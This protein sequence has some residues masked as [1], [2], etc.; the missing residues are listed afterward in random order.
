MTA[1]RGGSRK[2]LT[3]MLV[4]LQDSRPER[5]SQPVPLRENVRGVQPGGGLGPNLEQAWGRLRRWFLQTVRLGYVRRMAELRQ[6]D[7]SGAPHEILDPRDLK[8][9]RNLC[10][11]RWPAEHD[12]FAWRGNLGIARWGWCEL[13]LAFWP[14]LALTLAAGWYRWWLA[15]PP[16]LVLGWA[17]SFFRDPRR[18][19][20]DAPGLV[21]SPADGKVVEITRLEN[22]PFVGGPGVRIGIFLSVFNV[23]VNRAPLACRVIDVD[24]RPGAFLNALDPAS[25]VRNESMWIGLEEPTAPYRRFVCRQISG[26]IARR[27]VCDLAPGE[28]LARGQKFGMIKFGSRTELILP[29]EPGL[30]IEVKLGAKVRGGSTVLA[31]LDS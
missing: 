21:V 14:L 23:H 26:A 16:A 31:R 6:G 13:Q 22:D 12:R 8:Y 28:T 30:R 20:P 15:A 5:P 10:T 4:M 11:A 24:Y 9:C 18:T 17:I 2:N 27:I 3:A 29:D 7:T 19:I 1:S 25:A